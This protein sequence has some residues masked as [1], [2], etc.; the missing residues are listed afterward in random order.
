[1]NKPIAEICLKEEGEIYQA[2]RFVEEVC[3]YYHVGKE[4]FANVMLGTTEAIR[5]VL[6]RG[7]ETGAYLTV[8]AVK[9]NK[10]LQFIINGGSPGSREEGTSDPLDQAIA[11]EKLSRELF[12]IRSLSDDAKISLDGQVISLGFNI[13]S[14]DAERSINRVERLKEYLERRKV[15]IDTENA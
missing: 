1:M 2:E 4:Y 5:L 15:K 13:T 7:K 11:E 3:D 14:L 8:K 9:D 6:K 12:I 10:G